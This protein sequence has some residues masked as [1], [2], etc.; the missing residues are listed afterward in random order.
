MRNIVIIGAGGFIG[1]I[2]RFYVSKLNLWISFLSLPTGTLLINILGS[3]ILGF[4]IGVSEKSSIISTE[5]R[6]FLMV[7]F[8]GGFTTF[9]T[10]AG[11][12]LVMVHNG[13][14]ITVLLY[15]GLSISLGFAAV[16]FGYAITN[17]L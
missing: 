7:G 16:F 10:F 11:E 12:S 8:C 2:A 9:S 3:F 6:L 13:Q 5:L 4:L 1:S 15:T 14:F 17:L